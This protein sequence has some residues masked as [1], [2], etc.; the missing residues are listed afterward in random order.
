[1]IGAVAHARPGTRVR[2]QQYQ[3]REVSA[4]IAIIVTLDTRNNDST[5]VVR[6]GAVS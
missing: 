3:K 6:G 2:A 4:E 1:M 5:G